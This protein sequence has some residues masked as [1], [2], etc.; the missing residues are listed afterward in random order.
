[1]SIVASQNM[2]FGFPT[3]FHCAKFDIFSIYEQLENLQFRFFIYTWCYVQY[4]NF[5]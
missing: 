5:L 1:M 2:I 4:L 3:L